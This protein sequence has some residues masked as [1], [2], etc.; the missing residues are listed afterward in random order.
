MPESVKEKIKF[1]EFS[2]YRDLQSLFHYKKILYISFIYS[3]F[4]FKPIFFMPII[5]SHPEQK[6]S[7]LCVSKNLSVPLLKAL[8]WGLLSF[9]AV[10]SLNWCPTLCGPVD[11]SSPGSSV[12]HS[13]LDLLRFMFIETDAI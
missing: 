10:Q 11:Y 5:H 3:A 4:P 13:L 9:V 12:L 8:L 1:K 6:S 7:T 2:I